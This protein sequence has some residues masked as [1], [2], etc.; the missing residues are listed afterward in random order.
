MKHM[1]GRLAVWD[2]ACWRMFY[3]R[4]VVIRPTELAGRSRQHPPPQVHESL[5]ETDQFFLKWSIWKGMGWMHGRHVDDFEVQSLCRALSPQVLADTFGSAFLSSHS[6]PNLD[7]RF[8][9]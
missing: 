3:V 7:P 9:T 8:G 1:H 4:W 2:R 6:L 5:V